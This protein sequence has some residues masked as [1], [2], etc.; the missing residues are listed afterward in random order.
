MLDNYGR[1]VD[2]FRIS[3]T[4][5]CNLNC[6]YCHREGIHRKDFEEMK[7]DEI[8]R[9]ITLSIEFGIKY[10]KI[11]GGEP[12]IRE[13]IFEIIRKIR[14]IKE[15][16][17][18]SL[19]TN[20]T[21]LEEKAFKLK[22]AGLDRVNISLDTLDPCR[23][24]NITQ[25][26]EKI[27]QKILRGVVKAINVGLNP[28]KINMV[29]LKDIN[30]DEFESMFDFTKEH[31]CTLQ[32]IELIPLEKG[33]QSFTEKHMNLEELEKKIAKK[34]SKIIVRRMQKRRKYY[35]RNGGVIEFVTPFHNSEFCA[36]CTKM[37]LTYDGKLKPCLLRNDNLIDIITPLREGKSN[38]YLKKL[39]KKAIDFR[40]PY[41]KK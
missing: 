5:R 18:I 7:S 26:D 41:Y 17:N 29:M 12:L 36:N 32:C 31:G 14:N 22:D 20:G 24:S 34:A 3:I 2:N 37:R 6:V 30:E 8:I 23:F 33:E 27:H 19:V 21:L 4:N 39:F 11:T 35:L 10:I 15:I 25:M 9:I 1:P 28:L 16:K 40:E 38:Q 13:D